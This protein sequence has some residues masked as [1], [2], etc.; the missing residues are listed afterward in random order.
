[1][2][3]ATSK[4]AGADS[5]FW[6][7]KGWRGEQ[8]LVNDP[9]TEEVPDDG[10]LHGG[11]SFTVGLKK[12]H[13]EMAYKNIKFF[14]NT[15]GMR[16]RGGNVVTIT[17]STPDTVYEAELSP[18][19]LPV[20]SALCVS[21][22]PFYI[23]G[24]AFKDDRTGE[25]KALALKK[26]FRGVDSAN[27][28]SAYEQP[29][30]GIAIEEAL[31]RAALEKLYA[32]ATVKPEIA[33]NRFQEENEYDADIREYLDKTGIVYQAFSLLK[34]NQEIR[35]SE[36]VAR[37]AERFYTEREIAFYMLRGAGDEPVRIAE[38]LEEQQAVSGLTE[39][40]SEF[41]QL[42]RTM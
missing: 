3:N 21:V 10:K 12:A 39:D 38:L 7:L 28:L 33:Q 18:I 31:N 9:R 5:N 37:V 14:Q 4:V 34:A 13:Q 22:Q 1:M 23:Y 15:R 27:Y 35:S 20:R 6:R 24:T 11:L 32:A 2:Q 40:L 19:R 41:K 26:G 17:D 8:T 42:L 25:L 36:L 29:S 16:I 30:V